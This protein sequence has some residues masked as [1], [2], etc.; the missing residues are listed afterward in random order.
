V[1]STNFPQGVRGI[2]VDPKDELAFKKAVASAGKIWD[3][4]VAC[5]G[6]DPAVA[7]QAVNVFSQHTD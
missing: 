5:I 2:T 1:G 4:V 3:L 6:Y 7:R